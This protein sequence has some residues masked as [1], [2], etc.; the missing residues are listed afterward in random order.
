MLDQSHLKGVVP[1]I[2]TPLTAEEKVDEQGMRRLVTHVLNGGVH[3]IFV[4]GTTGEFALLRDEERRR[5]IE[6]VVSEVGG[7][8]PVFVGVG[9]SSTARAADRA[10]EAKG[11]GADALVA[12]LPYYQP[13]STPDEMV[14][15]FEGVLDATDLPVMLYNIPQR[16]KNVI[17]LDAVARLLEDSRVVGIKDSGEDPYYF[18]R[19]TQ[20]ENPSFRVFQGSE[21]L[22]AASLLMGCHGVVL[23]IANLVPKLC[24]QLYDATQAKDVDTLRLLYHHL[25][26]IN[27]I[28]W[29]EGTSGIGALKWALH[30]AGICQPHV[31]KPQAEPSVSARARIEAEL[32][33]V[34]AYL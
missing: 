11:L 4:A 20:M 14:T 19:L 6:L 10:Q 28:W 31:A 25:M 30:L 21:A 24:V 32:K 13:T 29:V 26:E 23:G 9:D 27:R 18:Y 2:A 1:P 3:G 5:S 22:A 33:K 8:V 34:K 15:H 16:V 17:H 7:K 12:V